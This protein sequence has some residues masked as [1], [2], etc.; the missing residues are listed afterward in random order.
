[1]CAANATCKLSNIGSSINEAGQNSHYLWMLTTVQT[2]ESQGEYVLLHLSMF[3][4][5][6]THY[7]LHP[8]SWAK[9]YVIF[10]VNY[11]QHL[12][13][14]VPNTISQKSDPD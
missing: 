4:D 3:T 1:M 2:Y 5:I 9:T 6:V 7:F 8:R 12:H 13:A 14:A 10:I 11:K